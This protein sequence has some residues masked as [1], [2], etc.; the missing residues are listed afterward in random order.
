MLGNFDFRVAR[1]FAALAFGV[2][3][4][5]GAWGGSHSAY[6]Y[7]ENVTRYCV[8]DYLAYCKQHAPEGSEVR[9]CMEAHRNQLSKQCIKALVDAGEVPKKYLIKKVSDRE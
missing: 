2:A 7:D 9:Y 8:D 1:K 4:T 3:L 6:A 5:G